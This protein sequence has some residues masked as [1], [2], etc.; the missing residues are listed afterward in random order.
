MYVQYSVQM[1]AEEGQTALAWIDWGRPVRPPRTSFYGSFD[2]ANLAC[3]AQLLPK[4][5]VW[6]GP[7]STQ[8][9]RTPF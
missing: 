7:T 4:K 2:G 5:Q 6:R 3:L 8:R 1:Y 9:I